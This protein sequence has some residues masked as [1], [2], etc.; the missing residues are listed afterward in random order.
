MDGPKRLMDDGKGPHEPATD[1]WTP[2]HDFIGV[3]GRPHDR[4]HGRAD[5]V[6]GPTRRPGRSVAPA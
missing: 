4:L 5:Q 2:P 6:A 3:A 1:S